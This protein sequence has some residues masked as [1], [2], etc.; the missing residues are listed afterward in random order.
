M[1]KNYT[2]IL[3]KK[4]YNRIKYSKQKIIR[5]MEVLKSRNFTNQEIFGRLCTYYR[6]ID[7]I[8][9]DID[10]LKHSSD[11]VTQLDEK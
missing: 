8:Y 5:R 9:E 1:D 10:D 7:Y 4:K 2:K 3:I 11:L 6:E